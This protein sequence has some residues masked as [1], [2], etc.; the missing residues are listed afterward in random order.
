MVKGWSSNIFEYFFQNVYSGSRLHY[1]R[2]QQ[3]GRNEAAAA[4]HLH[5]QLHGERRRGN[6]GAGQR[7]GPRAAG[8]LQRRQHV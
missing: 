7:P 4:L 8:P 3:H 5:L 6:A 1:R 2:E